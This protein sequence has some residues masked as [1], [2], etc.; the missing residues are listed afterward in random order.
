[1]AVVICWVAPL[2]SYGSGYMLGGATVGECV[3]TLVALYYRTRV[4]S[5]S[6]YNVASP[7][8]ASCSDGLPHPRRQGLMTIY[9]SD[10]VLTNVISRIKIF[11]IGNV[12]GCGTVVVSRTGNDRQFLR[13]P[14]CWARA[15]CSLKQDRPRQ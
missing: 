7:E 11:S 6:L 14:L 13:I 2:S 8:H 12:N 4:V 3:S 10:A 5:C 1:M 15:H 9:L